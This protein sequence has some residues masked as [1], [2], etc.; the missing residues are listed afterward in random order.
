MDGGSQVYIMQGKVCFSELCFTLIS[1]PSSKSPKGKDSNNITTILDQ[2]INFT[3]THNRNAQWAIMHHNDTDRDKDTV[4]LSLHSQTPK[5]IGVR[6]HAKQKCK[7][8]YEILEWQMLF[9]RKFIEERS[10]LKD[11]PWEK[12]YGL[13]VIPRQRRKLGEFIIAMIF[14]TWQHQTIRSFKRTSGWSTYLNREDERIFLCFS[15]S[16]DIN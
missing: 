14:Q 1:T 6:A 8:I 3:T 10:G 9:C 13:C 7:V 16:A 12:L 11:E 15:I 4:A 5:R 2:P